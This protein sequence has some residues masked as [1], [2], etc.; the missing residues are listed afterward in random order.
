MLILLVI[1]LF[2]ISNYFITYQFL[3][4]LYVT[5]I[6]FWLSLQ[7][8]DIGFESS[9]LIMLTLLSLGIDNFTKW[10]LNFMITKSSSNQYAVEYQLLFV[11]L[12]LKKLPTFRKIVFL[13]IYLCIF[14]RTW[15]VKSQSFSVITLIRKFQEFNERIK[16]KKIID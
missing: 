7:E 2:I 1:S 9:Q 16:R 12:Q 3:F 5:I 8:R 10:W 14:L 4:T 11:L 13:F 15:F 6:F